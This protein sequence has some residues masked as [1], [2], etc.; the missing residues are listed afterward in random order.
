VRLKEKQ[1]EMI[2]A[3]GFLPDVQERFAYLI[4]LSSGSE[5]L[6]SEAKI[7]AHLVEGCQSLVWIIG[8]EANGVWHFQSDADAPVVKG[9]A[10]ALADFYSG[11]GGSE[12]LETEPD[13]L[14]QLG[15]MNSLTENRRR[16]VT[17]MVKRI[18]TLV[19]TSKRD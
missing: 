7:P 10:W 19:D 11:V 18:R 17:Q 2:E 12:I 5:G 9:M 13:F 14:Q 6:S 1:E 4:D 15:L 16:G 3:Y 8:S